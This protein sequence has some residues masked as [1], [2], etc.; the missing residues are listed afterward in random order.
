MSILI[1]IPCALICLFFLNQMFNRETS[2]RFIH[3]GIGADFCYYFSPP[4]TVK[5]PSIKIIGFQEVLDKNKAVHYSV[6]KIN[7]FGKRT[8]YSTGFICGEYK[9]PDPFQLSFD[10]IPCGEDYRI[11]IFSGFNLSFGKFKVVQNR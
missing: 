7:P 4:F 2:R 10:Q 6:V 1:L 11:E 8:V 3:W 9:S 5:H